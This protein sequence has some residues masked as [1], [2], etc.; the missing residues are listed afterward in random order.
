M[1]TKK[2]TKFFV[3]VF[4]IFAI[5]LLLQFLLQNFVTYI[6]WRSGWIWN[7]IRLWKEII[8]IWLLIFILYF[9]RKNKQF[10]D[11]RHKFP[12]KNF[13]IIFLS[14]FVVV[15]LV[16]LIFTKLSIAD[17]VIS[18][19]YSMTGFLIFMI[20]FSLS[21]LFFWTK[22]IDLSDRYVKA[23]KWLLIASLFRWGIIW[24]VPRALEFVWYNQF[25]LEWEIW[26]RPPAA[27]YTQYD[28]GYVRNQFIFERPIS[29]GFF[30][31]ALWPLFFMLALR[32]KWWREITFWSGMYA[33]CVMSTFSRAARWAFFVQTFILIFLQ[34]DS[35]IRKKAW[36]AIIPVLLWFAVLT[37]IGRDQ[38]IW[39]SFSNTWHIKEIAR[40]LGKIAEKPIAWQWVSTAWP[41]SHQV[42]DVTAYN[43]ENQYLQIWLEYG[44]FGFAWWMF[45]YLYLH[46]IGYVAYRREQ[47]EKI[48]KKTRRFGKLVF[49]FSLWLLGLSIEWLVL[50]SFVDRM[51]VYPFMALFGI[52]YA[53][54]YKSVSKKK[55]ME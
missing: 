54:Y 50:H 29:R 34:L 6:L 52:V 35:K 19:R 23:L 44:V 14:I 26:A 37:Y 31:I 40:A 24:L 42:E 53:L 15:L 7:L 22:E 18:M 28:H 30:L 43:P 21:F 3:I 4:K 36:Y 9:L 12:L 27:Y 11:F 5:G 47:Q 49:A 48:I 51:I 17:Y 1:D 13:L 16:T 45:L 39:R 8:L 2:F 32:H 46:Y 41:A 25:S 33:I 20:F 55:S 10:K 38:I